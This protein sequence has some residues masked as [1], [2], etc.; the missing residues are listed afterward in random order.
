MIFENRGGNSL[1]F[2]IFETTA[3]RLLIQSS[4]SRKPR[5]AEA[6]L[7][8]WVKYELIW[9]EHCEVRSYMRIAF[10]SLEPGKKIFEFFVISPKLAVGRPVRGRRAIS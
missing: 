2:G 8:S 9:F 4:I 1:N 10:L 5:A 3:K 7:H 6:K